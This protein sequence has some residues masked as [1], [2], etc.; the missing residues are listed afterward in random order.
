MTH[1]ISRRYDL[2]ELH[3]DAH[4]SPNEMLVS[5]AKAL[6]NQ[7]NE[8]GISPWPTVVEPAQLRQQV[9]HMLWHFVGVAGG[10]QP[11]A[12]TADLTNL[13]S[14][15]DRVNFAKL[16]QVFPVECILWRH[17]QQHGAWVLQRAVGAV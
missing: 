3:N 11:G 1:P 13:I 9:H 8:S 17:V 5:L 12:F 4:L 16:Q 7:I 6:T 10:L 2:R 14:H 15:A